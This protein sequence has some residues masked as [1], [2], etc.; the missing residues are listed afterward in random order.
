MRVGSSHPCDC[1]AR[2]VVWLRK[3]RVLCTYVDAPAVSCPTHSRSSSIAERWSRT[4][5][6]ATRGST[7]VSCWRTPVTLKMR[8][9]TWSGA[10]AP[11]H[12]LDSWH[13]PHLLCLYRWFVTNSAPHIYY[14]DARRVRARPSTAR[15]RV[16]CRSLLVW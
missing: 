4:Q 3:P 12:P 11:Q 7:W 13:S 5:A 2:P 15:D 16:L 6:T 9:C 1:D 10:P 14:Y 8:S